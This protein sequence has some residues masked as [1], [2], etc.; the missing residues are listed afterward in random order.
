MGMNKALQL[1]MGITPLPIAEDGVYVGSYEG[2]RW[3]N[4]V[5]ITVKNHK[6]IDIRTIKP[7]AF[8]KKETIDILT[9]QILLKQSTDVDTVSGATAYSKAFLKAVEN[10]LMQQEEKK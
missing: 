3:S 6:I 9:K 5:E 4:T 7:Q 2:F 10:A 1:T 8:A